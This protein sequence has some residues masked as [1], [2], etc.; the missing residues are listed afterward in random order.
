MTKAEAIEWFKEITS[1]AGV[2]RD[3]VLEVLQRGSTAIAVWNDGTFTLGIEYGVLIALIKVFN[4]TA[5]D[6]DPPR[7][8][9]PATGAESGLEGRADRG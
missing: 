2:D 7:E 4:L 5:A 6:L 3:E 9:R 8:A 1:G